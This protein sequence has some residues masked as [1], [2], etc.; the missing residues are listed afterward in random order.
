[1]A[2]IMHG[3]SLDDLDTNKE[4]LVWYSGWFYD[5]SHSESTCEG[6]GKIKRTLGDGEWHI[7]LYARGSNFRTVLVTVTSINSSFIIEL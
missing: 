3:K 5:S 7:Y 2:K 6:F 1:M 4:Y